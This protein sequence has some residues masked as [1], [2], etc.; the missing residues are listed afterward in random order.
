[1]YEPLSPERLPLI[2]GNL[3]VPGG[4]EERL[5]VIS[6]LAKAGLHP[7]RHNIGASRVEKVR[8]RAVLLEGEFIAIAGLGSDVEKKTRECIDQLGI[9]GLREPVWATTSLAIYNIQNF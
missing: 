2:A 8:G 1:M 4:E 7:E 5:A 6:A 9:D 3:F